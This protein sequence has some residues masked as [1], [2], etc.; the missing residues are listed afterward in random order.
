[1]TANQKKQLRLPFI[2][3]LAAV[4]AASAACIAVN[5]SAAAERSREQ[6]WEEELANLTWEQLAADPERYGVAQPESL[7]DLYSGQTEGGVCTHDETFTE[8]VIP[9]GKYYPDG[10]AGA[11]YYLEI[12]GNTMCFRD[13]N[14]NPYG[15][16]EAWCGEREY[17]V[18]TMHTDD[19][20][21]LC[22]EWEDAKL[23]PGCPYLDK[24][25]VLRGTH[26]EFDENGKAY[27][28]PICLTLGAGETANEM[29]ECDK[30]YI[31]E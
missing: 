12:S 14:G 24:Y 20:A 29:T 2:I 19:A 1:M 17:K 22:A 25:R 27:I 11:E 8:P 13:K 4:A 26:V 15:D 3:A 5:V 31:P 23:L 16:V 6:A 28:A 18:I 9:D 21:M 7:N 30:L 10:N